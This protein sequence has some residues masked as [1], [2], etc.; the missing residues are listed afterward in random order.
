MNTQQNHN[1]S[2]RNSN[3]SRC[4]L[5]RC[6][7]WGLRRTKEIREGPLKAAPQMSGTA[8]K[9]TTNVYCVL[10]LT[11]SHSLSFLVFTPSWPFYLHLSHTPFSSISN[12]RCNIYLFLLFV[13]YVSYLFFFTLYIH[14]THSSM[15]FLFFLFAKTPLHMSFVRQFNFIA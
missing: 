15:L 14:F 2:H 11:L 12:T 8:P 10:S 7:D 13:C 5:F 9:A 4:L 1:N 6:E 3:S